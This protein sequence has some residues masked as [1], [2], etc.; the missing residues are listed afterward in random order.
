LF[1]TYISTTLIFQTFKQNESGNDQRLKSMENYITKKG[2]E[3]KNYC[4]V[5]YVMRVLQGVK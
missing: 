1:P 3:N 2:Y 5:G 4:E